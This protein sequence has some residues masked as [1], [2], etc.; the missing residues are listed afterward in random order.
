MSMRPHPHDAPAL[1]ARTEAAG[2][3]ARRFL[4]DDRVRFGLS[5][6]ADKSCLAE[7]EVL[8]GASV[9]LR[10]ETQLASAVGLLELD[11]LARRIVLSTPDLDERFLP[12]I[13]SDAEITSVVSDRPA[14]ES[15]LANLPSIT[16]GEPTVPCSR[17]HPALATEW[18]LF[19]SGT[20]G[21]P[22]MVVH[23]LQSLTGAIP[24]PTI[25]A[26]PI[27]WSTFYDIRR[28]GGL[29]I[30]LRALVGG[31]SIVLSSP[32]EPPNSFLERAASAGVS[33][34]SGTPSHWRRATLSSAIAKFRPGYVRLSGEAADEAVLDALRAIFPSAQVAH[35]FASTEAGVAFD[36]R[37]GGAGFPAAFLDQPLGEVEIRVVDGTLRIRSPRR[38]MRY[39]GHSA[40]LIA[41]ADGFVDTK[42]IIEQRGGRCY[43]VGRRDGVINVGGLKVY[44]EEV[45]AII[46]RHPAVHLSLVKSRRSPIVGAIV[47]ADVVLSGAASEE[48]KA[49]EADILAFCRTM[50]PWHKVPAAIRFVPSLPVSAAGK[51]LRRSA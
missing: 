7:R 29:Q 37:D 13:V 41:D 31:G 51:L 21:R 43:F 47:V 15:M 20:T 36:V 42:D 50:L 45:E 1:W 9:L 28:Y 33:H 10:T 5:A 34:I 14:A 16:I 24:P 18:V 19:T 44:P 12:A 49:L 11:G 40:E 4:L 27:V 26:A 35:A 2:Q 39:L 17:A 38:A 46:N 8:R 30:L 32:T 3:L 6:L 22:K 48:P 25:A 23:T